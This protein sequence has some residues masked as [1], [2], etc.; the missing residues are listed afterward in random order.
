MP[1]LVSKDFNIQTGNVSSVTV[2]LPPH[3]TGDVIVIFA[4]KDDATGTDPTTTSRGWAI[5][6]QGASSG[7][8]TA[9]VRCG[10]FIKRAQ[11]NADAD[12]VV[13]SSDADTWSIVAAC[14]RGVGGTEKSITNA[15]WAANVATY[16]SN[17]HGYVT[18]DIVAIYG[19]TPSAYDLT[20]KITGT[21]TN[22]FT[23]ATTL[24][25]GA[26]TSGGTVRKLVDAYNT[27]GTTDS[28][29][30]PF[31]VPGVTTNSANSA[32]IWMSASGA[33]GCPVNYPGITLIDA[34]D[35]AAEGVAMAYTIKATA[36]ASGGW[37]FYTDALN[38]NTIGFSLSL[39]DDGNG[40]IPPY[41]DTDYATLIHPFRG[42]STII[43]SDVW[44]TALTNYPTAGKD[45]VGY[46]VQVDQSG[47]PSYVDYTTA[48]NNGTDAD[49]IPFPATEAAGAEGT[50]DWFAIGY[51]KPFMALTFDTAGST[52]GAAGVVVWEYWGGSSWIALQSVTDGTTSFTVAVA[53][54]LQV[55]WAMPPNFNWATRSINGSSSL[56]FVRARCS[57]LYTTNP[58]IS[59]VYVSAASLLYDAVAASG[60]AGVIQYENAAN[61][62][63]A[64]SSVQIGG[65]YID[66][67]QTV[68]L[69]NTAVVGTY[70]FSLPRD[71]VDA[72][73][74]KEGG[75]VFLMFGDTSFNRKTWCIG[76]YR[77]AQTSDAQRNR[78]AIDWEQTV[79][80]TFGKTTTT[81][82]DTIADVFIGGLCPRGGG[83]T[84]FSHMAAITLSNAVINGGS[85][86]A[87]IT[88][89]EFLSL[90][91]ASPLQLFRDWKP[92][93]PFIIGGSDD[94]HIALDGFTMEFPGI[95]T[96]YTDLY[97]VN[98][99]L[100]C[101]YDEGVLGITI[102][103]QSGDTVHLTNGK[104]S[105]ETK[106]KF[107]FE[108]SAS[109]SADYDFTNLQV[110]NANVT[111]RAV[112]T[113][114]GLTFQNCSTFTQNSATI[115]DCIFI[116]S[117][118]TSASPGDADNISDSTFTSSGTG[119]GIVITG[120][121]ANMTLSGVTF[122][123]YAGTNGS[124][125]NEAIY[126]N[127]ASGTMTINITGGGSTPS[128]RTAGATVTVVNAVTVKITTKDANDSANIQNARVL[129][130]ASTG[131]TVTITR[132]GSTASVTHTAHGYITGQKVVI[133]GANQGE[134]NGIFSITNTGSNSY[135]YTIVGTP[136]TPA[137]GTI[138]S[139]R[140]ILDGL[141]NASGILQD[142][143]FAYTS[144][145]SVTGRARKGTSSTFYKTS[146]ISGTINSTGLDTTVFLVR[147]E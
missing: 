92:T 60:D 83:S 75:G 76:A 73:R 118:V 14:F 50:G 130:H 90:G 41:W 69:A 134:Y 30:A 24:D 45:A 51:S 72:A 2:V 93:I 46:C 67:G 129:L 62:T 10:W 22:T 65:T 47:G 12:F 31:N 110:V 80:T 102:N 89:E 133:A 78:F 74:F 99:R 44:G 57:T 63:P 35:S 58:T 29:G 3:E 107:N 137:T 120:T 7:A 141:T 143:A 11:T 85:S 81:V 28:T 84:A 101:H 39:L 70:Q 48:A 142:T 27:A 68:N 124:T 26:Y 98:P 127:I 79:D 114:T 55:R 135:D 13:S 136:A 32:V 19:I 145:L 9:A 15:S 144:D 23:I 91:N 113:F 21:T 96:P 36:G 54:G 56:Y 87:P 95:A 71:Y 116:D 131:T 49:V 97:N 86:T 4:G 6:A 112:H 59:Q 42:S 103:A 123:G 94:V 33:T 52:A 17:S 138:T 1:K 139:Y 105:S 82:S 34:V 64:T 119:H 140:A 115:Q 121:A 66:L 104:I 16:T 111:L 126:V 147:D 100:Q 106:W 43:T 8:T 109:G 128:I 132:S 117:T 125:G 88:N 53:D 18:N 20:G 61:V 37:N 108:S 38:T 40:Y 77:D 25:P 146:P 5:G 122:T